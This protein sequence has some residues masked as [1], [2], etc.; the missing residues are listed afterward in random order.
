MG[1]T[2]AGLL[3]VLASVLGQQEGLPSAPAVA[4]GWPAACLVY[5]YDAGNAVH[6]ARLARLQE[7]LSEAGEPLPVVGL[8]RQA[9]A[10]RSSASVG[11]DLAGPLGS[12]AGWSAADA[13]A[14][15]V[16]AAPPELDYALLLGA[17]GSVLW[18]LAGG[19]LPAGRDGPL[20]TDIG[21]NTWG[22]IKELFR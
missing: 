17:D 8:A 19:V 22:K 10:D 16:A 5:V 9:S 12:E 6:C 2:T 11:P 7:C 1:L 3:F 21:K 13:V 18:A 4:A 14:A 20:S 15:T